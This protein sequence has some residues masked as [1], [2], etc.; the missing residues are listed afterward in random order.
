MI[1]G[2]EIRHCTYGRVSFE[3]LLC[4]GL[5][6]RKRTQVRP[7]LLSG[8]LTGN[9]SHVYGT[10]RI[11]N[12]RTVR[13]G[14]VVVDSGKFRIDGDCPLIVGNSF[15]GPTETSEGRGLVVPRAK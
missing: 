15:P 3:K 7:F 4:F 5:T 12:V 6:R 2:S 9:R 13:C 14:K 8:Q 11:T 10:L 1:G